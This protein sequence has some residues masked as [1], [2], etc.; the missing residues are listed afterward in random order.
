MP[1]T[2]SRNIGIVDFFALFKILDHDLPDIAE[3]V[4][5]RA[6]GFQRGLRRVPEAKVRVAD[7]LWLWLW[8]Q[9]S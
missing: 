1:E 4:L 3:A 9:H 8:R 7:N 6:N 5:S 2:A